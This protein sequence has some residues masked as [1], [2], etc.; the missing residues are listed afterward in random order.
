MTS[1]R[2]RRRQHAMAQKIAAFVLAFVAPIAAAEPLPL[3]SPPAEPPTA[4]T[5]AD[6]QTG[7]PD[8]APSQRQSAAAPEAARPDATEVE[9]SRRF[10]DLR[11]ELLDSRA[12]TVDWWLTVTAILL[13]LLGL[14]AG[15]LGIIGFNRFRKIETEARENVE[16]SRKH[17]EEAGSL[18]DKIKVQR[19]EAES[20]LKG[21]TAKDIRDDPD[22]A[23][24]AAETVQGDP[25]AS[26]IDQAVAAAVLLQRQGKIEESMER[27][28]AVAI[29]S[30]VSDK[31]LAA[32]AWFS[33]GYL[34]QE[35]RKNAFEAAIDA[36]DK[37]L[38]LKPN[39]SEAYNNR[40]SAKGNLGQ[41]EEAISDCEEAIRLKPDNA[42]AYNNRG[43]A[44]N[45]QGQHAEAIADYDKAIRLKLDEAE[46]YNNRGNAKRG[47]GWHEEAL[48][49]YDKAI[50]LK[51]D[52]ANAYSN[53]GKTNALLGRT[54]EARRDFETTVSLA[55]NAGNEALA[56]KAKRALK[57][58][59][60]EQD[61]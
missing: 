3:A 14:I 38:W 26:P 61:P 41:Y 19:D 52:Y 30:E 29:I 28:R 7:S 47:L 16:S 55:R 36:Y 51:P 46:V 6:A 56:K 43:V 1:A 50:Q 37:A 23:R 40:G 57:E 44:K 42:E 10:N 21:L 5:T 27:W 34:I 20:I 58:L 22:Q 25:T 32:Q 49:D 39:F 59:S 4:S 54:G 60:G 12:K 2:S 15:Y 13:T 35:H 17:A 8:N 48:A 11:R 45:N 9:I 53:R 24:R 18:V 33:V 31:D